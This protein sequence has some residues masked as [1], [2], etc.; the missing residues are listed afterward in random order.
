ME[1]PINRRLTD[2]SY[3]NESVGGVCGDA[4]TLCEEVSRSRV[5]VV[6]SWISAKYP[7]VATRRMTSM[8]LSRSRQGASPVKYEFDKQANVLFVDRFLHTSMRYPANYGFV[9]KRSI[10][11]T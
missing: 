6:D 1:F 10:T 8:P 9:R 3:H 2:D 11:G 4:A 5:T 7:R